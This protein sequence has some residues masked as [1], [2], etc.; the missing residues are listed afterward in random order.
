MKPIKDNIGFEAFSDRRFLEA[1]FQR[2][3]IAHRDYF[4]IVSIRTAP[5]VCS[6]YRHRFYKC[7]K[8]DINCYRKTLFY[9][10]AAD[11]TSY[12]ICNENTDTR[13]DLRNTL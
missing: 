12:M 7:Y 9:M 11:C 4:N 6:R 8:S 1:N 5:V 2:Y 13:F 10:F 3:N